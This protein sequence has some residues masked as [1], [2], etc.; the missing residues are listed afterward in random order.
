MRGGCEPDAE[1]AGFILAGGQSSRMGT[2]KA[3]LEF[4][5]RP[6]IAH[7]VGI[8]TAA[9]LPVFI[10]GAPAQAR[11]A[12]AAHAPVIADDQPGL[13]PLAGVCA[14]LASSSA[15]FLV[16]LPVD[17]P[18]L[19]PSLI[20]YLLR[21]A[22]ITGAAVTLASVNG[23]QQTFPAVIARR[24]RPV[25]ENELRSR[26]LGCRAAFQAAARELREPVSVVITELLAQSGQVSHHDALPVVHWFL[27]F[28]SVPDVC[29]AL[30]LRRSRVT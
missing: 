24:A 7:A 18:L 27:N 25:L 12:L 29:F 13:G 1:A 2:D 11:Q 30:S 19:P 20:T 6:L 5:G 10:A 14:A 8:L 16:F 15:E 4:G 21:R 23:S 17:V 9:G 3:L 22:R 28:N 26:H